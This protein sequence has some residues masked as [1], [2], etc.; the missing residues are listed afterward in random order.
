MASGRIASR[1]PG[2]NITFESDWQSVKQLSPTVSIDEGIQIEPSAEHSANAHS[3][4]TR[5]AQPGPNV[6]SERALQPA[7]PCAAIV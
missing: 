1:H 6:K 2:S 3:P 7:K 4:R 5:T